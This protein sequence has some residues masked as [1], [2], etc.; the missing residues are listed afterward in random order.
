MGHNNRVIVEYG[1]VE[2]YGREAARA[3]VEYNQGH[4]DHKSH[5]KY[6]N[7]MFEFWLST[8]YDRI[9]QRQSIPHGRRV[10]TYL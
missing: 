5:G 8:E 4:I 3:M 6:D 9:K 10:H 2:E 1:S 7:A